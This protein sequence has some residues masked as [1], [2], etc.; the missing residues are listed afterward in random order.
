MTGYQYYEQQ[1]FADSIPYFREA[2]KRNRNH[3]RSWWRAANAL[4]QVGEHTKAQLAAGR[5]LRLWPDLDDEEKK[6]CASHCAKAAYMLGR[7]QAAH[8]PEGAEPLFRMAA[9][10]DSQDPYKHYSLGK[11]LLRLGR[12][13]E[14]ATSLLRA[15]HLKAQDPDIE[16]QYAKVLAR[17][18]D[19]EGAISAILAVAHRLCGHAAY[20]A[21]ILV[22][23]CGAAGL[24]AQLLTTAGRLSAVRADPAFEVALRRT[25]ALASPADDQPALTPDTTGTGRIQFLNLEKHFG[26]L[27]DDLEGTRRHFR[28]VEPTTFQAGD[29]VSFTRYETEKGPAAR[30][31]QATPPAGS[32]P[33]RGPRSAAARRR[34]R[35]SRTPR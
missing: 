30:L 27:R 10:L 23:D 4:H 31:V 19:P 21:G 20:H 34:H 25:H 18:N 26:F 17:Q 29:V 2:L 6:R 16:L 3:L 24:S 11:T 7:D 13:E 15:R 32:V 33:S 12:I 8:H 22:L 5:V 9:E 1:R 35:S 14:A 28:I